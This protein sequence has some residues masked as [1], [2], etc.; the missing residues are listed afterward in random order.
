M[1]PAR[2]EKNI[3]RSKKYSF[4]LTLKEVGPEKI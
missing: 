3:V 4:E 2:I 1:E